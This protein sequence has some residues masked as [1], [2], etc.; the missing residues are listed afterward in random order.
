MCVTTLCFYLISIITITI[1][2]KIINSIDRSQAH[3]LQ[4]LFTLTAADAAG[5]ETG[6]MF[7][8][9]EVIIRPNGPAKDKGKKVNKKRRGANDDDERELRELDGVR[10]VE[11]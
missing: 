8:G 1:H 4:D 9:S 3:N 7:E 11:K 2:R 6:E 5:T 10:G